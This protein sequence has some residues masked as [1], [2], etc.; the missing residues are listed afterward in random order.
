MNVFQFLIIRKRTN[1]ANN[2]T[3]L[4]DVELGKKRRESSKRNYYIIPLRVI[5]KIITAKASECF[6]ISDTANNCVAEKVI[7]VS[8]WSERPNCKQGLKAKIHLYKKE[9][10]NEPQ[11][12]VQTRTWVQ[13]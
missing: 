10:V 1:N 2:D 8:L 5:I 6:K 11:E 13:K 12:K 9:R 3:H 4:D 7:V